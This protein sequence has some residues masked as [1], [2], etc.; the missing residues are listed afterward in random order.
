MNIEEIKSELIEFSKYAAKV[1]GSSWYDIHLRAIDNYLKSE[2]FI[3]RYRDN[4]I[5]IILNED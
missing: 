1:G 4:Q 2:E 5:D 3:K